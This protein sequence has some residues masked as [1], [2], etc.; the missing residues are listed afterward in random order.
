M[1]MLSCDAKSFLVQSQ[2]PFST[3][4]P[5]RYVSFKVLE[6]NKLNNGI[7]LEYGSIIK[8]RIIEVKMPKRGKRNAYFVF[9]PE[10]YCFNYYK[11]IV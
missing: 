7:I 1:G 10:S 2:E 6:S 11:F 5:R 3:K 8:G 4:F 9:M